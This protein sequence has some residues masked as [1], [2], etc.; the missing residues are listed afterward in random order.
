MPSKNAVAEKP[1]IRVI[2]VGQKSASVLI[3]EATDR[4][5]S[6]FG[7]H[8]PVT[9]ARRESAPRELHFDACRVLYDEHGRAVAQVIEVRHNY[10]NSGVMTDI[11]AV[12]IEEYMAWRQR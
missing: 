12:G 2:V 1:S 7:W 9:I 6:A 3:I 4:D 10:G 5:V 8:T 11:R